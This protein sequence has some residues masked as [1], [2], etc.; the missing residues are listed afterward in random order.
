VLVGINPYV[1]EWVNDNLVEVLAD[2]R[3][4]GIWTQLMHLSNSQVNKL[5]PVAVKQLGQNVINN[6]LNYHPE[7]EQKIKQLRQA[8]AEKNIPHYCNQQS[9]HL[10][11]S[12]CIKALIVIFCPCSRLG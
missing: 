6:A 12:M 10:L 2:L 9:T 1:P 5:S 3:V 7:N 8:I 4:D 11:F